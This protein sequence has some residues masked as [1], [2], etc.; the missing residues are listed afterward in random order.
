MSSI[1]MNDNIAY[2]A[3]PREL[4]GRRNMVALG[5][6][7]SNGR[8]ISDKSRADDVSWLLSVS[9]VRGCSNVHIVGSRY[10]YI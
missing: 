6:Q 9:K 4:K 1:K 7:Q 10:A 5:T 8:F 3:L 2:A